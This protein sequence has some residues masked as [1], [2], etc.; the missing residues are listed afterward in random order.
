M[1]MK[2]D[3]GDLGFFQEAFAGGLMKAVRT[4]A[5]E[6]LF[7]ESLA[8]AMIRAGRTLA[9]DGLFNGGYRPPEQI[10]LQEEESRVDYDYAVMEKRGKEVNEQRVKARSVTEAIRE[11]R[12]MRGWGGRVM[13]CAILATPLFNGQVTAPLPSGL[14]QA[15]PPAPPP[16]EP[17][18]SP[19]QQPV[20]PPPG[21]APAV[22]PP[23]A[24]ETK[25]KPRTNLTAILKSVGERPNGYITRDEAVKLI[26]GT[27]SDNATLSIWIIGNEVPAA[28][29]C[30][31]GL[32]PTKGLPGRVM[33]HKESLLHRDAHR[34]ANAGLAVRDR[35]RYRPLTGLN[36]ATRHQEEPAHATA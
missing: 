17:A 6:N 35:A 15:R 3:E 18:P 29:V 32:K 2:L 9:K 4:L 16:T 13:S 10:A 33:L 23:A 36:G 1:K 25:R 22:P 11:A 28:I 27:D 34:K 7:E 26:G 21:F 19:V 5:K 20:T 14:T 8:R 24:Q 12:K 30:G 31:S